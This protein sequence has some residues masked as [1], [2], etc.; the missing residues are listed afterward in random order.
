MKTPTEEIEKASKSM[1]NQ[2]SVGEGG[3]N[4]EYV[5]YG[6]P[7]IHNGIATLLNTIARTGSC[8]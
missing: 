2:K 3:L 1:K 5:K 4:A 6:P 7:K 8:T